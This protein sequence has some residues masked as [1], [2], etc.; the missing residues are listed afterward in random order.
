MS[1]EL[2]ITYYF[3]LFQSDSDELEMVPNL[4]L[5]PFGRDPANWSRNAFDIQEEI[6]TILNPLPK[7]LKPCL[8]KDSDSEG[9]KDSINEAFIFEPCLY[10]YDE[11]SAGPADVV[12]YAFIKDLQCTEGSFDG[13]EE[14]FVQERYTFT[15]I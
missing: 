13:Y 10:V 11:Q 3:Y 12:S 8:A 4:A 15:K 7:N 2:V 6:Q 5:T 14:I 1:I 9:L